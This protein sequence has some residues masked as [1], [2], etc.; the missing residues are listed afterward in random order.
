MIYI[1]ASS[2][3]YYVCQ[4]DYLKINIR[5]INRTGR[6]ILIESTKL[7]C[8]FLAFKCIHYDIEDEVLSVPHHL[9]KAIDINLTMDYVMLLSLTIK[10]QSLFLKL[11]F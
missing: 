5:L 2:N 11:Y 7:G 1:F 4:I 6:S 10:D 3:L 8:I 9:K